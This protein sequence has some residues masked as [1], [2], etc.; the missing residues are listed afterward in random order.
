[1][2]PAT[3]PYAYTV[4]RYMHD[5]RTEE[6]LNVGVLFRAGSGE[7]A[8]FRRT[9]AKTRVNSAFAGVDLKAFFDRLNRIDQ[10][11]A[12]RFGLVH[13]AP[14]LEAVAADI[15]PPDDSTFRW[16][17]VVGGLCAD[18]RKTAASVYQRM[19]ATYE[20][21]RKRVY[22]SDSDVWRPMA[23]EL[24]RLG[25]AER[26]S[27]IELQTP[28]RR[29]RLQHAWRAEALKAI[30]PIS[31]DLPTDK[32]LADKA[33]QAAGFAAELTSAQDDFK[34][35]LVL[36]KPVQAKLLS[37]FA[38]ARELIEKCAD[39]RIEIVDEERVPAVAATAAT[40]IRKML[41][42]QTLE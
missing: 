27:T 37:P 26:L 30:K 34:V 41:G 6:F 18:P 23:E 14:G 36:G 31:L 39:S 11:W 29:H 4:L 38:S 25:I 20:R 7:F 8:E 9:H 10:R 42:I 19:V 22:R 2:T 13:E 16:S 33:N 40:E 15:V 3:I 28:M 24:H 5:V 21:R 1:M 17:P 12:E 32:E 35:Y